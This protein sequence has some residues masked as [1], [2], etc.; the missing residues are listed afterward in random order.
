MS[1]LEQPAMAD[2]RG[3]GKDKAT[4]FEAARSVED[5]LDSLKISDND[6]E[7]DDEQRTTTAKFTGQYRNSR[8]PDRSEP[9]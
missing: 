2:D 9:S 3:T 8:I 7:D 4:D 1:T 5:A 6:D